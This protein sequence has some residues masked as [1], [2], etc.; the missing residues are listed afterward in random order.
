MASYFSLILFHH[1]L[2]YIC[3]YLIQW[4]QQLELSVTVFHI[5]S[6]VFAFV[7]RF[8]SSPSGPS[9][10]ALANQNPPSFGGLAQQGPGFGSQQPSSFSG[11]GQPQPQAGG[12]TTSLVAL[13]S[14]FLFFLHHLQTFSEIWQ[15][16]RSVALVV[17]MQS[18]QHQY[19]CTV[20]TTKHLL[21][22]EIG[23]VFTSFHLIKLYKSQL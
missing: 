22:F 21:A 8:A 18:F 3:I 15:A 13:Y 6:C 20:L 23:P 16:A 4:S 2:I 1:Y 19:S 10:G 7:F 9:F 5:T 12:E 11:F 17:R 14:P